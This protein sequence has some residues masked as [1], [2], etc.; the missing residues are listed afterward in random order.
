L[1]QNLAKRAMGRL[2]IAFDLGP[3]L[4]CRC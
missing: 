3:M 1:T 2:T 4:D